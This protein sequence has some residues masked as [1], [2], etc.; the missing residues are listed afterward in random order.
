MN[1][2][3]IYVDPKDDITDILSD[4]KKVKPK[5]VALV[6]PKKTD[7]FHSSVN[8]KLIQKTAT[9][10]GK[11]VVLVTSDSSILKL[12]RTS[13]IPVAES[14]QSRPEIPDS[15]KN[16]SSEAEA[17]EITKKNDQEEP[18]NNEGNSKVDKEKEDIVED[19]T[20]DN[21]PVD[22]I[23]D[24]IE[25]DEKAEK[26][27][28]DAS[29]NA[30]KDDEEDKGEDGEDESKNKKSKKE[31]KK[32]KEKDPFKSNRKKW[33]VFGVVL[34]IAVFAFFFWALIIVPAVKITVSIKTTSGNFSE[35][36]SFTKD[37]SAENATEGIF[38]LREEV[39]TKEASAKFTATGKKD[40][41]DKA[42]GSLVVYYQST[43]R[44]A[45]SI[46]VGTIFTHNGLEYVATTGATLAWDGKFKNCADEDGDDE[47]G[48]TA[49]AIINI[50][51]SSPGENYNIAASSR[52]WTASGGVNVGIYNKEPISGGT[53]NIVTIVQQSDVD[54]ALDKISKENSETGKA[55]ILAKLSETTFPI[56]TS[57]KVEPANPVS[58]P[59]VGEEVKEGVT[60]S[61][62][63]STTF[64]MFTLDAVRIE[65][66]IKAKA[67]IAEDR[68][69]YSVGNPFLEYFMESDSGYGAKLKTTYKVGPRVTE[70]DI[71]EKSKG[72]KIGEV[73]SLIKSING[74]NTVYIEK[75]VFWVN[76]VPEDV[77]KVNVEVNVEE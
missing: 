15:P 35:N 51:A 47:T 17:E 14:L 2:A 63:S 3:T 62:S 43:Q 1:K 34:S 27:G 60:P 8:I 38:F 13:K 11:V 68:E 54:A 39:I 66:Y 12:A 74:V 32:K 58:V 6:P 56:E 44:F 70:Q 26:T 46:P 40:L 33:V 20:S 18:E 77:N 4:L 29:K 55:E 37:E 48:C 57:F 16:Q 53:S 67:N 73:L 10:L 52:D 36:V 64:K 41:G 5:I 50:E 25:K 21:K 75:S 30:E 31:K 59:A 24:S 45:Q 22:E 28:G 7:V 9:E 42:K 72:K 65:E 76:S 23:I 19:F 69:I 49:S 61:V 71:L